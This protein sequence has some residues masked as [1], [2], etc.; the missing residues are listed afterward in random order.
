[1]RCADAFCDRE[2]AAKFHFGMSL[3]SGRRG[4][5]ASFLLLSGA[6]LSPSTHSNRR[7]SSVVWTSGTSRRASPGPWQPWECKMERWGS[8]SLWE[9]SCVAGGWAAAGGGHS[10]QEACVSHGAFGCWALS[11]QVKTA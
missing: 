5:A 2:E 1:M 7:V 10:S 8:G 11:P 6:L 4:L 9:E 3:S